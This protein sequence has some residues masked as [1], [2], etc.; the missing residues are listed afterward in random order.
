MNMHADQCSADINTRGRGL[1]KVF[2]SHGIPE[3][4]PGRCPEGSPRLGLRDHI[5]LFQ[6]EPVTCLALNDQSA[7]QMFTALGCQIYSPLT[8]GLAY[9]FKKSSC[10]I[11]TGISPDL[12]SKHFA[13]GTSHYKEISLFELCGLAHFCCSPVS[14]AADRVQ[15]L[16]FYVYQFHC[17]SLR[18]QFSDSLIS[19]DSAEGIEDSSAEAQE[20]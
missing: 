10:R 9:S 13:G 15:I 8:K 18:C 17:H 16:T 5:H 7:S 14:L 1:P 20:H 12:L 4:L 2:H 19:H 11:H 6:P 3:S